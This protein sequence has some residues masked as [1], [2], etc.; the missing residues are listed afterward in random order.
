MPHGVLLR[1]IAGF[2]NLFSSV[3]RPL[4]DGTDVG[5][6]GL[7]MIPLC[8]PCAGE[9]QKHMRSIHSILIAIIILINVQSVFAMSTD[10]CGAG[11]CADCHSITRA[12]AAQLLGTMVDKVN[13]VEFSEVPGL[14]VAE[15]E[16]GEKKLPVYIDFS[17]K[18]LVS[19]KIIRLDDQTNPSRQ[20]G[21]RMNR[22]DID[23]IPLQD[24]LL[25]GKPTAKTKVIVFTDP[26]CPFCK[27][28]HAELKEVVR[29]DPEIAFLIKLF[30][31]EI[32]PNAYAISKSIVCGASLEFLELSYAGQP[33]PPADCETTVVDQTLALAGE[34]GIRST[35]TLVL[36][37]GSVLPGFKQADA[38]LK[39]IGSNAGKLAAQ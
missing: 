24:A 26:E 10:G 2:V 1:K 36:P 16:K 28:L 11:A 14:C 22:V 18:F 32:H 5:Y 33:V 12:E 27:K 38:L 6:T 17:K 7:P 9:R 37:D 15:V 25:L 13:H 19:G 21:A 8:R 30:P 31:L 35:P 20:Q 23:K 39:L 4:R 34:L 3:V 29:R